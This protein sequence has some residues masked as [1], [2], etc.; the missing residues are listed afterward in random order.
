MSMSMCAGTYPP[1]FHSYAVF[2]MVWSTVCL[3]LYRA[4]E[5]Q[6]VRCR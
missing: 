1:G 3:E 4:K 5:S 2:V 6:R